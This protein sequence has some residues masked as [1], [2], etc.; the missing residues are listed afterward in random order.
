MRILTLLL[1]V[2]LLASASC[3]RRSKTDD[4]A[5]VQAAATRAHEAYVAA[6]N[7]NKIDQWMAA[8]SDDVVYLVPNRGAIVGKPEVGAWLAGYLQE[9]TTHWNKVLQDL[10]VSG[11]W[12][13]G[14]YSYT[15]S[16][17]LII[18]DTSVDGGGT[19]SDSGWGLIAY[20]RDSD[21]TW[22]VARDAWGSDRPAR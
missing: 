7:S 8:L 13:I 18:T 3:S 5:A 15:A 22:R 14:R 12:A 21:G 9:S 16:D 6:I 17:T 10:V 20:H 4:P 11:D 2:A 1:A 19:T